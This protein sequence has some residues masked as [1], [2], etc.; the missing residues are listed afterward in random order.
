MVKRN[1]W[2]KC[3]CGSVCVRVRKHVVFLARLISAGACVGP[4]FCST[5]VCSVRVVS[6]QCNL[7]RRFAGEGYTRCCGRDEREG[8]DIT[9][10]HQWKVPSGVGVMLDQF[11]HSSALLKPVRRVQ[12]GVFSPEDIVRV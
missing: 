9:P 5:V 10:F 4:A 7:E 2:S 3:G 8:D 1:L 6:Y 11:N 12:F